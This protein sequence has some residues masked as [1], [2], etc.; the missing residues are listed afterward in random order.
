MPSA[1]DA[2]G[3]PRT[4]KNSLKGRPRRAAVAAVK[5]RGDACWLCGGLIDYALHWN[6]RMSFTVDERIPR[7]LGGSTTD[8]TNL[9]ACHRACNASRGA[10]PPRAKPPPDGYRRPAN[11]SRDW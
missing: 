3:R 2:N 6:D 1:F 8:P 11:P 4:P 5:A 9:F 10:G 7:S